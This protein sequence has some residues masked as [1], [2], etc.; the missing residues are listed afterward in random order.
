[1]SKVATGCA[2]YLRTAIDALACRLAE[3]QF[4][5]AVSRAGRQHRCRDRA[6]KRR[7]VHRGHQARHQV[8]VGA[9][10]RP[11]LNAPLG[12]FIAFAARAC[13]DAIGRRSGGGDPP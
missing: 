7:I 9:L 1:M 8:I 3:V 4:A 13:C 5:R 10:I 6:T 2:L 11:P 12:N